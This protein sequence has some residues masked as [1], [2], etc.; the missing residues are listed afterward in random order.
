MARRYA[1][2]RDEIADRSDEECRELL[3][4]LLEEVP[5][6][7]D[8]IRGRMGRDRRR[9]GRDWR[10]G[11]DQNNEQHYPEFAGGATSEVSEVPPSE[12]RAH[13]QQI[14]DWHS[15]GRQRSQDEHR[16]VEEDL[17][18]HYGRDVPP[19]TRDRANDAHYKIEADYKKHWSA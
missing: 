4:A 7:V 12:Q 10:S 17:A 3:T 16:K 2:A 1:Y 6:T 14:Q 18:R 15:R 19:R 13:A 9:Y 5:G 11:R 8:S